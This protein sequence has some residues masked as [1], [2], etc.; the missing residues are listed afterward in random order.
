MKT[1]GYVFRA[2][3]P[4]IAAVLILLAAASGCGDAEQVKNEQSYR[5]AGLEY[6]DEGN[7]ESAIL[8]FN[9]ALSKRVGIVSNLEEDINFYK[10][11]AQMESGKTE[12][13]IRTYTALID[14]DKENADA[15]YLRGCAY[16]SE[17]KTKEA[18]EDFRQAEKNKKDSGE[19]CAGIYEQLMSAGLSE[20][21]ASYLEQGLKIKGS[22]GADCLTRGKLYLLSGDYDKA[23]TELG[24]ALEQKE[25]S[26]NLYLG[27]LFQAKGDSEEAETYYEAYMQDNPGDSKVLYELGQ[28]AAAQGD[29][30]EAVSRFEQGMECEN[31]MNKRQLWTAKIA[32]M[33]HGGNFTAALQEMEAYLEDYPNDEAAQREYIFLKTR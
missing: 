9:E 10:A 3:V 14:Y 15:Y 20:E 17:G 28:I 11:Y 30:S 26:A 29:Y 32:A 19:M 1:K 6:L 4:G 18:A 24:E 33:E 21:A 5:K 16:I 22:K 25:M 2:Y 27:R 13:A 8:A 12:D 31:L 7:F 23:E